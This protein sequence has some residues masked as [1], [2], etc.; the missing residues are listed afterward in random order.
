MRIVRFS[1]L[2]VLSVAMFSVVNLCAAGLNSRIADAAE[3]GDRAGVRALI[4]QKGTDLN[5]PQADG[6]TALHW[7][8]YRD[9]LETAK[10]LTGAKAEVKVANRYGS[11]R[12]RSPART[13]TE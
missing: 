12:C 1:V 6:M 3:A 10:L 9:D 11:R 4:Q 8:V 2:A 13:A 7:A 5:A